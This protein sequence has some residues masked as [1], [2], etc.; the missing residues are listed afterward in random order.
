MRDLGRSVCLRCEVQ[1]LA[2]VRGRAP[3]ASTPRSY[4][5]NSSSSSR[6][7]H[8][9][10]AANGTRPRNEEPETPSDLLEAA[11]RKRA[12]AVAMFRSI[13]GDIAQPDGLVRPPPTPSPPPPSMPSTKPTEP[14]APNV[15]S[16]SPSALQE[17]QPAPVPTPA[18]AQERIRIEPAPVS[19]SKEPIAEQTRMETPEA[20]KKFETPETHEPREGPEVVESPENPQPISETLNAREETPDTDVGPVGST[21]LDIFGDMARLKQM[22]T[23]DQDYGAALAFF[24]KRIQ[25]QME[26]NEGMSEL[27][28]LEVARDFLSHLTKVKIYNPDDP[29][30]PSVSR[31]TEITF[32][33]SNLY[34]VAWGTLIL[35]LVQHIIRQETTPDAFSTLQDYEAA[36]ANRALLI[37]DL[38]G[39]WD[40]FIQHNP[41]FLKEVPRRNAAPTPDT[42]KLHQLVPGLDTR[43]M[44]PYTKLFIS[45]SHENLQ[46]NTSRYNISW[47]AYATYRML[48]DRINSNYTTRKEASTFTKMMK[49][50]LTRAKPPNDRDL[51]HNFGDYPDLLKYINDLGEQDGN[52]IWFMR[53]KTAEEERRQQRIAIHSRIGAALK[54]TNLHEVKAAWVDFWGPDQN[55][56]ADR[57][58]S[59]KEEPTLFDYFIQAFMQL[60]QTE[61]TNHVWESMHRIK[62]KPTIKT[63]SALIEGCSRARSK[64]ALNKMWDNL[65]TAGIQLDTHIWTSRVAG[66]FKSGDAEGG[67]RALVDM[68]KTWANRDKNPLVAVQPS[69]EPVNAAISGLFK[70]N[71]RKDVMTV[72]AWAGKLGINPDIHTFNILLRPLVLSSDIPG[73]RRLLSQM[74]DA[75]IE[76]DAATFTVLFEGTMR[77][78]ADQPQERQLAHVK[79]FIAEMEAC[80]IR[81]NMMIYAKIIK[82]LLDQGEEGKGTLKAVYGQILQSGLEP[83]PHIYTMIVEHFFSQD[84]PNVK[85]VA[86]LIKNRRLHGPK[87]NVDRVFWERVISGFCQAGEIEKAKEV[88]GR[89]F[90]GKKEVGMTFGMLCDY[91]VGLLRAGDMEGARGLVRRAREM[92]EDLVVVDGEKDGKGVGMR[93]EAVRPGAGLRG[94]DGLVMQARWWRHRFWRI[95]EREGVMN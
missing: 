85:A 95:A 2:A 76:A 79:K 14:V 19:E 22:M 3:P 8:V 1:L 13:L 89:E 91:L 23:I 86:D 84:P 56:D 41:G 38:L 45:L 26:A 57:I 40:I 90:E 68:E 63:W 39:S 20:P 58:K 78:Y 28:K 25:P 29:N 17:A 72:L 73:I 4:S 44:R 50:I 53:V 75:G 54:R 27:I 31:I 80:G 49:N 32:G 30:L 15:K 92:R 59:M 46:Q 94:Q 77:Y 81:A 65:V 82:L 35:S 16:S 93:L 21:T 43:L 42:E 7:R 37:R 36:M 67:I 74:Q 66:L 69:I 83:T 61:M 9:R 10:T 6:P 33:F 11:S 64:V 47:A 88:F 34:Y 71:R 48:T 62:I 18:Q 24:E 5:S 70:A 87:A 60:R 12:A 55:P 52:H 51:A